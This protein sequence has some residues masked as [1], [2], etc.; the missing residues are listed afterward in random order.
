MKKL[1]VI[2]DSAPRYREEI[3]S[4]MEVE[5]DCDWYF[6]MTNTDIKEMNLSLLRNVYRY[7]N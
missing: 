6:G 3:Y 4:R 2:F 5:Y 1:C 7:K